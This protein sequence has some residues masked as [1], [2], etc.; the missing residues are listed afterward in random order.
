MK[1]VFCD[2]CDQAI[3][4]G[5]VRTTKKGQTRCSKCFNRVTNLWRIWVIT[6]LVGVVVGAIALKQD[7]VERDEVV[8]AGVVKRFKYLHVGLSFTIQHVLRMEQEIKRKLEAHDGALNSYVNQLEVLRRKLED[9]QR[10]VTVRLE[11][12]AKGAQD[13][14][15]ALFERVRILEV[16]VSRAQDELS[17][18]AAVK[19]AA[20]RKALRSVVM[21]GVRDRVRLYRNGSGVLFK[22]VREGDHWVYYGFT[23]YHV[24]HGVLLYRDMRMK[25]PKK[26]RLD[27]KYVIQ[28]FNDPRALKATDEIEVTLVTDKKARKVKSLAAL[29]SRDDFLVFTFKSKRDLAVSE[30]ASNAECKAI[31]TGHP[32]LGIGIHPVMRP[33]AYAGSIAST[34]SETDENMAVH[35]MAWP[36]MSGSPI[37]DRKTMK[38]IGITQKMASRMGLGA[39]GNIAFAQSLH[40]VDPKH[41]RL[42]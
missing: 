37:F 35:T 31:E 30:L 16:A 2:R 28:V 12:E 17:D 1:I 3:P 8:K 21:M 4:H 13:T 15:K 32:V 34:T 20:M 6:M 23:A 33:S 11:T 5:H 29:R 38:V 25:I 40:K 36:G 41:R 9:A 18:L 14:D 19:P 26:A 39:N 42:N 22:R 27:P 7:Y 24:Y 10:Q